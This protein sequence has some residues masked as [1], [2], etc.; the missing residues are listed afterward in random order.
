MKIGD[1]VKKRTAPQCAIVL[2]LE[3]MEDKLAV[4]VHWGTDSRGTVTEW[5]NAAD[6]EPFDV[7]DVEIVLPATE[8]AEP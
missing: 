2:E 1:R 7:P 6:L 3:A 8:D 4:L 5:V